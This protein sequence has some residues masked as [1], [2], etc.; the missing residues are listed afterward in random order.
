MLMI[1]PDFW[2]E[3]DKNG[4][5]QCPHQAACASTECLGLTTA[6]LAKFGGDVEI[7]SPL[8]PPC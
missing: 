3:F 2:T 8:T 5:Y 4:F 7:L 1:D 6:Y